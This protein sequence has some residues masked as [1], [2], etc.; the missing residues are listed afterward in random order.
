MNK[1]QP[2]AATKGGTEASLPVLPEK[3]GHPLRDSS[4]T[5]NII[6][7]ASIPGFTF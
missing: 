1:A 4:I 3:T 5:D 2:E 6:E 7:K